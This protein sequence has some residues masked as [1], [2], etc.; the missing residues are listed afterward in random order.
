MRSD[1]LAA[2]RLRRM[3]DTGLRFELER[4][5]TENELILHF[6]PRV[7]LTTLEL[8]GVEALVRWRHPARG[9]VPAS[10]FIA[11]AERS[12]LIRDLESWVIRETLLQA[13][14]WLSDGVRTG[15]SVNI[16]APLLS[17]E[18]FLR[19]FERMLKMHGDPATLAFEVSAASLGGGE[20]PADG[21]ARL[22]EHGVRLALDDVTTPAELEDASWVRWDYVKLGRRLVTGAASDPGAE[23]T[24]RSLVARSTELGARVIG[25]GAEDD[26]AIALLRDAGAYM[27]QGYAIAPPLGLK[28]LHEWSEGHRTLGI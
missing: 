2:R 6:Q 7:L 20:R 15:V 23:A 13:S 22:R 24:L 21:L 18:P 9:M 27:V 28:E 8:R 5:I 11:A 25:V 19:L 10:E 1:A 12:G 26:R 16:G 17:D 14:V 3:S 4:A